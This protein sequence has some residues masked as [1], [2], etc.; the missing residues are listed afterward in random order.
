MEIS[1]PSLRCGNK[2]RYVRIFKSSGSGTYGLIQAGDNV[3]GDILALNPSGGNVGINTLSPLYPLYVTSPTP[4][5]PLTVLIR[6]PAP[7]FK[8]QL[9]RLRTYGGSS[10][11]YGAVGNSSSSVGVYGVSSSSYGVMGNSNSNIGVYG[12]SSSSQGGYLP[13]AAATA[14]MRPAQAAQASMG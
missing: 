10:S 9:Q 1:E 4:A 12:V 14:S 6:A 13:A 11:G 5:P 7:A 2:W 8:D 3:S